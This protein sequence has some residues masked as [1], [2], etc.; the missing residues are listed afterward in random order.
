MYKLLV[1][2]FVIKL[3]FPFY[4]ED[5]LEIRTKNKDLPYSHHFQNVCITLQDIK[6]IQYTIKLI[7][8]IQKNIKLKSAITNNNICDILCR[9]RTKQRENIKKITQ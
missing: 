9:I 3:I 2:I 4:E 8:C 5:C 1:I 6:Y 7:S